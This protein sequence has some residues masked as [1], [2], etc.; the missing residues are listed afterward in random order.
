LLE[1]GFILEVHEDEED[2]RGKVKKGKGKTPFVL[3]TKD[4]K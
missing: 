2:E 1:E 3:L 4:V